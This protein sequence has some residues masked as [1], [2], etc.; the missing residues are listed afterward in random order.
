M[1]FL[2]EAITVTRR[3]R[4]LTQG[5]LAEMAG[6]TQAALSRYETAMREPDNEVL[7][8]I[9]DAL[10]VTPRFLE[11]AGRARGAMA[12]DAHMRR[13]QTAKPTVWKKLEAQLNVYR[14]HASMLFEE[15]A[16]R[17]E[18]RIPTFDPIATNPADAARLVRMQWRM[19]IGPVRGLMQW[20][21]AAGCLII[22]SD[23]GTSRIDGLSQWVDGHP[24]MFINSIAPTDRKRLTLAHELGHLVLHS[25]EVVEDVESQANAFAAEFLMPLDVIRP[26]LRN[27]QV[28]ILADLKREWGVSMAAIVE[29]AYDAGLIKADRRTSVYKLFSARGWKTS[30]PVSQ[31]LTPERP[32]LQYD[33]SAALSDRGLHENDIASMAGFTSSKH[34]DLIPP[35]PGNLHR[36][37]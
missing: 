26:Q 15:I 7:G 27:L 24:I 18:Q 12:V 32:S 25:E 5:E 28:N 36:V 17:A 31:E 19:P 29:R 35:R 9:A 3:A 23:F 33:I 21:E 13:R 11:H 6:V 30:E 8:R 16:L 37:V 4:G 22:E 14:M 34:N 10:G 20:L 2:G 1:N